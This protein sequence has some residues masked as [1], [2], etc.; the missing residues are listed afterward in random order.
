MPTLTQ[1]VARVRDII[2]RPARTPEALESVALLTGAAA[3]VIG[4]PVSWLIFGRAHL[5]ITGEGSIGWYAAVGGAAVAVLAFA[6]GR[7]AVRRASQDSDGGAGDRPAN[8]L[9]WH[10]LIAIGGAYASIALLGWIGVSVLLEQSFI[11]APVFAFPGAILVGVAFAL[12]AY[13]AFLGAAR[14]TPMSLSLDLAVFLVVGAFAAMLGS[15]DPKWW[16]H[17]LSSLGQTTNSAAPAF[18]AT[19]IISGVIITTIARF[20]TAGLPVDSHAQRRGRTLMRTGLV[21][22]GIFLA[23]VGVFPVNAFF[24]LHNTV[25]TGMA[26][27]FAVMI[28]ALPWLLPSLPRVFFGLGYVYVAVIVLLAIFF[29]TGYYN[30]TAV[31][32]IAAVLIFSWIIVFLRT[33]SAAAQRPAATDDVR[34]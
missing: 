8:L 28:C 2:L 6:A 17:N 24:L 19:L 25:A 23:C 27:I 9:R 10:D 16:Q 26:V 11:G 30:L 7:L 31:E 13:V 4:F 21:L 12:T 32:L 20:A 1:I 3:F 18:N 34:R 29:A 33:A 15:S 14:L 5:A 22:V